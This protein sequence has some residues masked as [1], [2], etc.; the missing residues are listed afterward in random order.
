MRTIAI[1][2]ALGMALVI[3]VVVANWTSLEP[4]LKAGTPAAAHR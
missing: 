3:G 2:L 4:A 1:G